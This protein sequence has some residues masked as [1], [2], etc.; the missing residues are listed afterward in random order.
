MIKTITANELK[1][2]GVSAIS[3]AMAENPEAFITVRG[4]N[5]Y[6]VLRLDNYNRLRECEL[7]AALLESKKDLQ[8]GK[9]HRESVKK[10]I[11]RITRA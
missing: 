3:R 10:H 5:S 7:T 2:R 1:T 4:K 11:Q 6:V 8:E 9:F